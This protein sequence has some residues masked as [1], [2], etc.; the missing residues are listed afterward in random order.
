[1]TPAPIQ[2]TFETPLSSCALLLSRHTIRH[3]PV[4]TDGQ[5]CGLVSD[6]DIFAH[7]VM[8]P[9]RWL[10]HEGRRRQPAP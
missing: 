6:T 7:G 5:P 3:L 1:M 10:G 8:L 2:V 4:D 9:D